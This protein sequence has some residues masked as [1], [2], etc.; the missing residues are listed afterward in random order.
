MVTTQVPFQGKDVLVKLLVPQTETFNGDGSE[1]DFTVAKTPIGDYDRDGTVDVNDVQVVVDGV[2]EVPS[3]I[4]ANTGVITLASAPA[5]GVGNVVIT[6]SYEHEPIMAQEVSITE[7]VENIELD[8]LGSDEKL[9]AETSL[10]VSGS[11]TLKKEDADMVKLFWGGT[12]FSAARTKFIL[13]ITQVRNAVTYI[14]YYHEVK[15]WSRDETQTAGDITEETLN[16]TAAGG[17][18]IEL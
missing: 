4:D 10:K 5:V 8:Q 18:V 13:K 17:K 3:A 7:E 9:V 11:L 6:Y 14:Y 16:L 1:T 15:L 2:A 12:S